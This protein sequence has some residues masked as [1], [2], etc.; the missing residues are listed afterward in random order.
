[1]I[2]KYANFN[3]RRTKTKSK[4]QHVSKVFAK[5]L[6]PF[7]TILHQKCFNKVVSLVTY[8]KSSDVFVHY[9]KFGFL[10]NHYRSE[11]WVIIKLDLV[12]C[13]TFSLKI[14]LI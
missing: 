4:S 11:E 10:G 14:Y 2:G 13:L 9:P 7:I 3:N 5:K 8:G 12:F 1:M 6:C